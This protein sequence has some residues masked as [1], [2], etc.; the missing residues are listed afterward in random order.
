MFRK[1]LVANRGEIAIRV[2]RACSEMDI[3]TVAV[4]S[5]L[6]AEA[7]HTRYADEAYNVGPGPAAQSYLKVDAILEA[8]RRAGAEAV[9]P[10]YG[11]LAE[12][13]EFAKAV[14][15]QGWCGSARPPRSSI[16]WARR[17]R[18]AGSRPKR[19]WL[20]CRGR[21]SRSRPSTR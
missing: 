15:E 7:P 5:E 10:G 14:M 11:F 21:R 2:M 20:R 9:H 12:N 13:A 16:R 1:L 8:A 4:Y 17:P 18:R 19:A 3:R 6:D